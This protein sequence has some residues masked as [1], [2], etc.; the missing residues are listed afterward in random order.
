MSTTRRI[1]GPLFVLMVLWGAQAGAFMDDPRVAFL[2]DWDEICIDGNFVIQSS[3][4]PQEQDLEWSV[5]CACED[6]SC[7]GSADN[8]CID[9][10]DLADEYCSQ[11][12][13]GI[14]EP[15]TGCWVDPGEQ[16]FQYYVRCAP[17]VD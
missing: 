3:P 16:G 17:C 2:D 14:D 8:Y 9:G 5:W 10:E 6:S 4:F 1:V 15:N 11:Y 7:M 13:C 12:Y